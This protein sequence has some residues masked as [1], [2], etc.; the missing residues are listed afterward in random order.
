MVASSNT[1]PFALAAQPDVDG[2]TRKVLPYPARNSS[3]IRLWKEHIFAALDDLNV[4]DK[5][6]A[7]HVD[8][9]DWIAN[10]TTPDHERKAITRRSEKGYLDK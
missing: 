2:D 4:L 1:R 9:K 3:A 7:K 5:I 8:A 10:N 6:V